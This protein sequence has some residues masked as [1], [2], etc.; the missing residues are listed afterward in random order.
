[1][2]APTRF[3]S[4]VATT[5]TGVMSRVGIID[6]TQWK[7]Y[8]NDFMTGAD[9]NATDWTI[10]EVGN[11][12]Q[13]LTDADG[14]LLLLTNAAA[15]ND[16]STVYPAFE[17]VTPAQSKRLVFVARFKVS[18]ATQTDV[19]V[20]LSTKDATPMGGNDQIAFFKF[21]GGTEL[22]FRQEKDNSATETA[23]GINLV[24]DT[25][26]EIAFYNDGRGS[27]EIYADGAKV[28]TIPHSANFLDDE[29]VG[30]NFAVI[31]GE[32]VSKVMTI[33]YVLV[34]QER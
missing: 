3:P 29:P 12:S 25:F 22:S 20:G 10:T 16:A 21:D 30:C 18:D 27:F 32:A 19:F 24:D 9:F 13:V 7:Y 26:I 6:P 15:D 31:N 23:T 28:I 2:S 4:G 14:G 1:M 34:A 17:F 33:D 5:K 8:F 11:G